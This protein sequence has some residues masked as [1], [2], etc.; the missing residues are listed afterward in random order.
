MIDGELL[1]DASKMT[2]NLLT[3]L[4][5]IAEAWRQKPPTAIEKCFKKCGFSSDCEYI[6]VSND[7]LNE[8][9]KDDWCSLKPSGMEFDEYV[10]YDASE[11]VCEI[12]SVDQVI[13]D[14]RTCVFE[15]KQEEGEE[16][17]EEVEAECIE[18]KVGFLMLFKVAR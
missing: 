18:N 11:S 13:Q 15:G 2:I 5:F 17:E 12:Q 9:E 6:D 16:K 8:Q 7:M 3:A 10:S 4:H 1:G 14:H